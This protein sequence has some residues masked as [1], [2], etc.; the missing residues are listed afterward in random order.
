MSPGKWQAGGKR[1]TRIVVLGTGTGVGKTWVTVALT[2]ALQRAG[3]RATALKPIETG[4]LSTS[5]PAMSDPRSTIRSADPSGLGERS[6]AAMLASISTTR[7]APPPYALPDPVSPHL[8]ARRAGRAIELRSVLDYVVRV[9]NEVTS[10][11]SSFVLVESAGGCLSPLGLGVSNADLALAL[12]PAIWILVAPDALGV[13]H[14]VSATLGVLA[15]RRRLPDHVVLSAAR[16]PDAS[17]GTNAAELEALGI[18]TPSAT[19]GRGDTHAL[20]AF[21]RDLVARAA[22]G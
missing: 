18:V 16:E 19:V 1:A 17:T 9:E 10:H 3:A 13:L 12:E 14:D 21:A 5:I 15:A 4:V 22:R 7:P 2:E 6:D 20:E 11:V 8:A